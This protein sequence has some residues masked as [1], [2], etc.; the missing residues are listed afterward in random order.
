[1]IMMR[2]SISFNMLVV[3]AVT[4][5]LRSM[6]VDGAYGY[7]YTPSTSYTP[8]AI[9]WLSAHATFYGDET[10]SETMG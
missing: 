10:A 4:M 1:M 9:N 3:V 7:S 6:V 2:R 8:P 5:L